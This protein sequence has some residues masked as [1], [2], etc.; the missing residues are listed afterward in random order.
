M[1]GR[2]SS[3]WRPGLLMA[4]CV[5]SEFAHLRYKVSRFYDKDDEGGLLWSDYDLGIDWVGTRQRLSGFVPA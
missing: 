1:K 5:L 3:I 2:D 4:F